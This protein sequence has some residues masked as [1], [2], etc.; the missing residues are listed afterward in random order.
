VLLSDGNSAALEMLYG[1]VPDFLSQLVRTAFIPRPGCSFLVADFAAI[2]ARVIAWLAGE[3]WRMDV[4]RRERICTVLSIGCSRFLSRRMKSTPSRQKVR[5]RS[6]P[7][8]MVAV[9][10][11]P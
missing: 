8:A 5:L 7:L 1:D 9:V 2:E 3:V 4:F 11:C 10:R 6:W